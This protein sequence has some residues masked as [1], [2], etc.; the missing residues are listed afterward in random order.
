MA[1]WFKVLHPN[2]SERNV[3]QLKSEVEKKPFYFGGSQVPSYLGLLK[4]QKISGM[5]F[6]NVEDLS[7]NR[8]KPM[9]SDGRPIYRPLNQ[10]IGN[11]V[12]IH[13][14]R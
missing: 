5:G 9:M 8:K 14:K 1:Y 7:Q 6:G 11:G 2:A 10:T 12:K 4:N 3:P 13:L